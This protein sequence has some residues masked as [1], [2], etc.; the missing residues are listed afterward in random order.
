MNLAVDNYASKY[1]QYA[2]QRE[3][4]TIGEKYQ[5]SRNDNYAN[6]LIAKG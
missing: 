4:V 6:V 2:L 5:Y 1:L 3:A